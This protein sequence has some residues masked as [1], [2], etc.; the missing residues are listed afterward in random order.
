MELSSEEGFRGPQVCKIVGISYRQLDYW[1]R[2][3]LVS[4]S[5]RPAQ[6][7]GSQRLYSFADLVDLKLIKNLLDTGVSLQ[8]VRDAIGYLHELGHDLSGV[9]MVSDGHSV[10]A[11]KSP[12]EVYDLLLGGQGVFG[13]AIDPV[14]KELEG[15]VS[16]LRKDLAAAGL[17]G[18]DNV[19]HL[20]FH[21]AAQGED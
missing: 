4:P 11:L 15:S 19:E 3:K 1:A 10:Y 20:D 6:G 5:I 17:Q 18:E 21:R 13:I 9:T 12:E 8:R 14:L 2:T 7:S 16:A